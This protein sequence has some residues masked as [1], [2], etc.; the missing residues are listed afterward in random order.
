MGYCN[1]RYILRSKCVP[2]FIF[3]NL[4]FCNVIAATSELLLGVT[5]ND[6]LQ[7]EEYFALHS[8]HGQIAMV[9]DDIKILRIKI[10]PKTIFQNQ[11]SNFVWL[12]QIEHLQYN[13]NAE[14]ASITLSLPTKYLA[15]SKIEQTVSQPNY[16]SNS[17]FGS[18]L[19]Y[20]LTYSTDS[21]SSGG[22]FEWV[23]FNSP[24]FGV[25]S[26]NFSVSNA[27]NTATF[28]R[29]NTTYTK[30]FHQQHSRLVL[31]DTQ[32]ENPQW[33]GGMRFG[34]VTL[35]SRNY[36]FRSQRLESL[37][38]I[39]GVLEQDSAIDLYVN[40]TSVQRETLPQGPYEVSYQPSLD[41][42]SQV[43]LKVT[44][45]L[46]REHITRRSLYLSSRNLALGEHRYAF[47]LGKLRDQ[48]G[49]LSQDYGHSFITGNYLYGVSN[50]FHVDGFVGWRDR[51]TL[52][53][54]KTIL[55]SIY[56]GVL[57]TGIAYSR[58]DE[59]PGY[60]GFGSLQYTFDRARFGFRFESFH[61]QY[62]DFN[63]TSESPS[64]KEYSIVINAGTRLFN[65]T[66]LSCLI[67]KTQYR[68]RETFGNYQ[69]NLGIPIDRYNFSVSAMNSFDNSDQKSII[70]SVN[71]PL[72]RSYNFG[73]SYQQQTQNRKQLQLNMSKQRTASELG[74]AYHANLGYQRPINQET[75]F[76]QADYHASATQFQYDY[77]RYFSNEAHNLGLSG[78]VSFV[79]KD[80]YL[81]RPIRSSAALVNTNGLSNINITH[82]SRSV[83]KT[84][85]SGFLLVPGMQ[86]YQLNRVGLDARK[87]PLEVSVE[88]DSV[89]VKPHYR[90]I[91]KVDFLV[92]KSNSLFFTV[93]DPNG[94]FVPAGSSL[95]LKGIS[96]DYFVVDDGLVY[97]ENIQTGSY[98]FESN[99][100]NTPCF[101]DLVIPEDVEFQ[102]HLGEIHCH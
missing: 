23:L 94:K 71:F 50:N 3:S 101:G 95:N 34:G 65:R 79:D 62:R 61:G 42:L 18:Y 14:T 69:C 75:A 46:G 8:N 44:D 5:F 4:F 45:A 86:A 97:L 26:Q 6:E 20:D 99:Y 67:I 11:G 38:V 13:Y 88:Q 83:G 48:Y 30:D 39:G 91:A 19:N 78:A 87:L 37:N 90:S 68:E 10:N 33:T 81:T 49:S 52:L 28:N 7:K 12:D 25:F 60:K 43:E 1:T 21:I 56:T 80:W 58:Y 53:G 15:L 64:D 92:K 82:N 36:D 22:L 100:N 63:F 102:Q 59:E 70:F 2:L 27:S 54:F 51:G 96:E 55:S 98:Q 47:Q 35:S 29:L 17:S 9:V 24:K 84:N 89:F 85:K 16:L 57:E 72:G 74:L 41:R 31:G 93:V 77:R 73:S 40:G 66:F 76:I 32:G